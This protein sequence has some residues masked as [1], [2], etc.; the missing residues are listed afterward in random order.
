MLPPNA[1]WIAN[2]IGMISWPDRLHVQVLNEALTSA[3]AVWNALLGQWNRVKLEPTWAPPQIDSVGTLE[4][5]QIKVADLSSSAPAPLEDVVVAA[6]QSPARRHALDSNAAAKIVTAI[7]A[8]DGV[9][10]CAIVDGSTGLL[11]A[12]HGH[13]DHSLPLGLAAAAGAKVLRAHQQA[14]RDLGLS[15]PVEEIITTAGAR[16]H[17]LRTLSRHPGLFLF[18]VLDKHRTNLALTRYKLTEA[19]QGLT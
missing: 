3:S 1:V 2:R 9:L 6:R 13:D 11:V 14:S 18:A 16:H 8:L 4:G 10:G 15:Q 5:F 17:V 7:A 19:E 12:Q